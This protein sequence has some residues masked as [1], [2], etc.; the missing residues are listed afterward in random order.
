MVSLSSW[1]KT[2]LATRTS[3]G[4]TSTLAG[5]SDCCT[6]LGSSHRLHRPSTALVRRTHDR[7]AESLPD[8]KRCGGE[9]V[10]SARGTRVSEECDG[11]SLTAAKCSGECN[12]VTLR[13]V[14][15]VQISKA[16]CSVHQC[17]EGSA[18]CTFLC[19]IFFSAARTQKDFCRIKNNPEL[20]LFRFQSRVTVT[21]LKILRRKHPTNSLIS[22][23]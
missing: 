1:I 20:I 21:F 9:C 6:Q 14:T 12:T 16:L 10:Q 2:C 13:G 5:A 22:C 3:S 19:W 23:F 17:V 4:W 11:L 7:T 15:F 18:H 8:K